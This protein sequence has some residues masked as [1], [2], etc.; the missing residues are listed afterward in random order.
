MQEVKKRLNPYT[1]K[2]L[3]EMVKSEGYSVKE[4]CK[5]FKVSKVTFYRWKKRK[6][7]EDKSSRPLNIKNQTTKSLERLVVKMRDRANLSSIKIHYELKMRGITNPSTGCFLAESTIRNIFKRY[8]RGY[9]YDKLKRKKEKIV[10]YEKKN[11]GELGHIDVKKIK[12]IKGDYNQKRYEALLIDDCTRLS[13]AEI[14]PDKTAI[15]LSAFLKSATTYFKTNYNIEFERLMSDNGNEFTTRYKKNVSLH[16]FEAACKSLGIKHVYTR[17]YRPQT[18]GKVERIWRT[19]DT[20]FYS[21]K[22]FFS[23]EQR[24]KE[25]ARWIEKYNKHRVHLGIKGMTPAQ[26][27]A[28]LTSSISLES[29]ENY[30]QAREPLAL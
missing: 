18:N 25:L 3:L 15:T 26:K 27:W 29:N 21:K 1:R 20:E 2:R 14:I 24:E 9:K 23:P 28:S 17:P 5:I 13:Y 7:F 8:K 19:L 11:P 12:K 6:C 22:W 16:L 4:A 30:E 10:R